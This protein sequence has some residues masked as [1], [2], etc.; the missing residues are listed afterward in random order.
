MSPPCQ[1]AGNNAKSPG[2]VEKE[3]AAFALRSRYQTPDAEATDETRQHGE[4]DADEA[5]E[6]SLGGR[7]G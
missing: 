4:D 6:L 7:A 5:Q 2:Y 3:E 1:R